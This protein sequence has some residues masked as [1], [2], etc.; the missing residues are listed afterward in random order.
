MKR[1][2]FM[3]MLGVAATWPVVARAQ[4]RPMPTV[5]LLSGLRPGATFEA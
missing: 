1:R 5:G 4:Q 2:Q 3:S